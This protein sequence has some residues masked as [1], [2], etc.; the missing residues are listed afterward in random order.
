MASV[1]IL[2]AGGNEIPLD[3]SNPAAFGT[4]RAGL[5]SDPVELQVENDGDQDVFFV[6]VRAIEHPDAQVGDAADTYEAVEFATSEDGN[7]TDQL[8]LT[9]KLA[10]GAKQ[11]FWARWNVP[12]DAPAGDVVWAIE[13][14]ASET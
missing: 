13:A 2:D 1:R 12:D 8:D 10:P 9:D 3:D 11:T 4:V 7:Y 5:T 14:V 6:T